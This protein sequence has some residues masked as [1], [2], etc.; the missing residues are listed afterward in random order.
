MLLEILAII[1][2]KLYYYD[3][4]TM[5][6]ALQRFRG[7][8]MR[9][10]D[11]FAG[12]IKER[13]RYLADIE[14]CRAHYT[15]NNVIAINGY[16]RGVIL[17]LVKSAPDA[18]RFINLTADFAEQIINENSYCIAYFPAE[19]QTDAI[20]LKA[21]MV[22]GVLLRYVKNPSQTLCSRAVELNPYCFKY[23]PEQH[24]TYKMCLAVS[25][26]IDKLSY[27]PAK[28]QNYTVC[29]PIIRRHPSQ[30]ADLKHQSHALCLLAVLRDP[31]AIKYVR[32]QTEEIMLAAVTKSGGTIGH[33]TRPTYRVSKTAIKNFPYGI[34]H[35]RGYIPYKFITLVC[36]YKAAS[37]G[38]YYKEFNPYNID[39]KWLS[40]LSRKSIIH[41]VDHYPAVVEHIKD[42]A[43][44]NELLRHNIRILSYIQIDIP[45]ILWPDIIREMPFMLKKVPE[46]TVELC[47][48]AL[49]QSS[50]YFHHIRNPTPKQFAK[51]LSQINFQYK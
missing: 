11:R 25:E 19:F 6:R 5:L 9:Y 50:D 44:I 45:T 14:K 48:I 42:K 4:L 3:K 27:I 8:Y 51:Y 47:D 15:D 30:I 7:Y 29:A 38:E 39:A 32:N 31:Y 24:K 34:I 17:N 13:I 46:Q 18:V 10:P 16:H 23:I 33:I 12:M 22:E 1:F 40:Q 49:Q 28:Y 41:L 35:L 20:C 26:H 36:N 21:I 37:E 43:F 2:D